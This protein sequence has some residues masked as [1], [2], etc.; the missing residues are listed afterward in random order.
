MLNGQADYTVEEVNYLNKIQD[1][2]ANFYEKLLW[3]Y[4]VWPFSKLFCIEAVQSGPFCYANE[5]DSHFRKAVSQ[6]TRSLLNMPVHDY[7]SHVIS[8]EH[9]KSEYARIL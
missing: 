3:R 2:I 6:F 9:V 5:N 1:N 7:F 4:L 8:N